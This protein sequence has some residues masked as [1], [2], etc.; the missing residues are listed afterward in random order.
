MGAMRAP[1][2]DPIVR[3]LAYWLRAKLMHEHLHTLI[4]IYSDR[5]GQG[6]LIVIARIFREGRQLEFETYLSYWLSALFV[7]EQG[8]AKL[9]LNTGEVYALFA[10]HAR[11]LKK[12]RQ[13]TYDFSVGTEGL[14]E[15]VRQL[16]WCERLHSTIRN[17]IGEIAQQ[18]IDGGML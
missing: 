17:R 13:E 8:L 5:P 12:L 2:D 9:Q 3:L 11:A 4:R 1:S 14:D 6:R 18:L 15:M 10:E 16:E 7:I